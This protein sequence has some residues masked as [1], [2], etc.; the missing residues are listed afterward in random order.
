MFSNLKV[1]KCGD[2]YRIV[3]INLKTNSN[4]NAKLHK[5]ESDKKLTNNLVRT[6]TN[7]QNLALCNNFQYFV[8]ITF[9]PIY[10][11]YNLDVLRSNFKYSVKMLRKH[12]K[13]PVNYLV[14]PEQHKS[15][16]WHFHCFFSGISDA[17]F[18]NS[19]GFLDC[20][21]FNRLG[22]TNIQVIQNLE[23]C[24]SYVTKY[25]SKN[26]GNGIKKWKNSY[27]CSSGLKRPEL[28]EDF[29][30]NDVFF[31]DTFFEYQNDYCR[32]KTIRKE[33]YYNFF[34]ILKKA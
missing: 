31:D 34:T 32:L 6:K 5:I 14:V 15:G 8:T 10:D 19:F 12:V 2:F 3:S 30:Y 33:N 9:N 1:Y 4:I 29:I 13:I 17:L 21:Y 16:A 28:V 24:S 25:I 7:I 11:R 23:R 27:F 18:L 20:N 22:H 26:L